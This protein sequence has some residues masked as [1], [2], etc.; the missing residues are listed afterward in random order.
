M[1]H[2]VKLLSIKTIVLLLLALPFATTAQDLDDII[3]TNL[4]ARPAAEGEV[5]AIYMTLEN[6]TDSTITLVQGASDAANIVEIHE[7]TMENNVMSMSPVEG[8]TVEAGE[9]ATLEPGGLHIMLIDLIEDLPLDTAVSLTLTFEIDGMDEPIEMVIAAPVLENSPENTPDFVLMNTW[10]RPTGIMDMDM[11]D[12][13]MEDDEADMDMNEGEMAGD[14]SDMPMGDLPP[15]AAYM[16]LTNRGEE[17]DTLIAASS[18]LIP[19]VEVHTTEF[20]DDVMRMREVEDGITIAAGERIVL[21]P[22]G[23]HIMLMNLEA[24]LFP[25]DAIPLTLTFESGREI[26][27]AVPVRDDFEM[28][29]EMD[30]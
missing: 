26:T 29:M 28:A 20:E 25:G 8:I 1:N 21:E 4:W 19:L 14:E 27:I 13:S 24:N 18:P 12:M 16:I 6:P 11:G 5:T 9:T 17:D 7:T 23:F 3:L 10:A 30:M 22:G 15:S 2:N